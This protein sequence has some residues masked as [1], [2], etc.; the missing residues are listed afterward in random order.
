M[1]SV[2]VIALTLFYF[3]MRFLGLIPDSN[4]HP[5]L[6]PPHPS[7][8]EFQKVGSRHFCFILEFIL[9][10]S[11]LEHSSG[12]QSRFPRLLPL[13]AVSDPVIS[14]RAWGGQG[15]NLGPKQPLPAGMACELPW[16]AWRL[17]V[18]RQLLGTKLLVY[19]GLRAPAQ[20]ALTADL[21]HLK[22]FPLGSR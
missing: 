16:V 7:Q 17:S 5:T 15:N 19:P 14:P 3:D 22:L 9:G 20:A 21:T 6:S 10:H 12:Q 2:S 18:R 11:V 8:M 4:H 13:T 1:C